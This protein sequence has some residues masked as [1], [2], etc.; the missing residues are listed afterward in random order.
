MSPEQTAASIATIRALL[1]DASDDDR[2]PEEWLT[3]ATVDAMS[4][5]E[6]LPLLHLAPEHSD[7]R[8][9]LAQHIRFLLGKSIAGALELLEALE[10]TEGLSGPIGDERLSNAEAA[11]AVARLADVAHVGSER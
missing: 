2:G 7:G 11:A 6:L 9:L 4:A 8:R 3:V 1:R 5:I 10:R